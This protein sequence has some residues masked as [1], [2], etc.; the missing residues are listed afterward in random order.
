M[1]LLTHTVELMIQKFDAM[2]KLTNE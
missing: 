2:T 1:E